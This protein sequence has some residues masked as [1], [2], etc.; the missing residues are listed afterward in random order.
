[1]K[2]S[3]K[4]SGANTNAKRANVCTHCG[5]EIDVGNPIRYRNGAVVGCQWCD[6]GSLDRETARAA[7]V[8]AGYQVR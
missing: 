6:F 7:A 1:M 4:T 5:T 2:A 3:E 8:R